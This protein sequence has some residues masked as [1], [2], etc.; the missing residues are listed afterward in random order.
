[1]KKI[2]ELLGTIFYFCISATQGTLLNQ[3]LRNCFSATQVA[4]RNQGLRNN[5]LFLLFCFSAFL[6]FSA[7]AQC[8]PTITVNST[9][10]STC[11]SDGSVTFT[12]GGSGG[13]NASTDVQ[14]QLVRNGNP[15]TPSG[16]WVLV[17]GSGGGLTLTI[18]DLEPGNYDITIRVFCSGDWSVETAATS[19]AITGSYV[20]LTSSIGTITDVSGTCLGEI[21]ISWSGGI[22]PVTISW[23]G[24][25]T[26][27]F[28]V[29]ENSTRMINVPV[30]TFN[31]TVTDGCVSKTYPNVMMNAT[32]PT[33]PTTW[34]YNQLGRGRNCNEVQ[35]YT[36]YSLD[37][38]T[39]K[40]YECGYSTTNNPA[41][42]VTWEPYYNSAGRLPIYT[43]PSTFAN[44]QAFCAAGGAASNPL[45]LHIRAICDHN[46]TASVSMRSTTYLCRS[47][48]SNVIKFPSSSL[49][50]GVEGDCS[51]VTGNIYLDYYYGICYPVKWEIENVA[52]PGVIIAS[53]TTISS[54]GTNANVTLTSTTPFLRGETYKVTC[55]DNNG[56]GVTFTV[57]FTTPAFSPKTYSGI[58]YPAPGLYNKS[59]IGMTYLQIKPTPNYFFPG[60]VIRYDSG[61]QDLAMGGAGSSYTIS[62]SNRSNF[63]ATAY[64]TNGPIYSS[65]LEKGTY[66]FTV[67][68]PAGCGDEETVSITVSGDF[69]RLAD[70]QDF[71]Y[72][73][74]E[75]LDCDGVPVTFTGEI[76]LQSGTPAN[77]Y[78]YVG[79]VS[80]GVGS[81]SGVTH[82]LPSGTTVKLKPSEK[83]YY[84][85][86]YTH[87]PENIGSICWIV[88]KEFYI[89]VPGLSLQPDSA[90][91]YACQGSLTGRIRVQAT[92]GTP[93]YTYRVTNDPD[94]PST[95]P[96]DQ[97]RTDGVF[98]SVGV[99]NGN[100]II[101]VTD[102]CD[103]NFE[104]KVKILDLSNV[105]VIYVPY[106]GNFCEGSQIE[107]NCYSLG[108][109]T[110]TWTK[111]D[112]PDFIKYGQHPRFPCEY[113]GSTGTYQVSVT[114]EGCGEPTISD[115]FVTA[116]PAPA[117][118]SL[119]DANITLC[120]NSGTQDIVALSGATPHPT[121]TLQWYDSG[122]NEIPP[123]TEHPTT[124]LGTTTYYVMPIEIA[125]T[126]EP[127]IQKITVSVNNCS[128]VTPTATPKQI[129]E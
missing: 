116:L 109:T 104:M 49:W 74:G 127:I 82:A 79:Q 44:H 113:P 4:F 98:T 59:N 53:G 92:S 63:Q 24:T 8:I 36:Y 117:L 13:I 17:P 26:G 57:N 43:Y 107:L 106:S 115:A 56:A 123:P 1:M 29:N 47:N 66:N 91:A 112:D 108:R 42:V 23:T 126:C 35:P 75:T 9:T 52:D 6:P 2:Y 3:G 15:V 89:K 48:Y 33:I 100:Y 34:T 41:D 84:I 101:K 69:Y 46:V 45:Y 60:T 12:V 5:F 97:T 88:T 68:P 55:T 14:Y 86:M 114:A 90:S 122:N 118:A 25:T 67:I 125:G 40:L 50:Q 103:Y 102:F 20:G 30:G 93:P 37:N 85:H 58:F 96:E 83:P 54:P 73:I 129:C 111:L 105:N 10:T 70:Q 119:S 65:P 38:S 22:R 94:D 51:F 77:T 87:D 99:P 72:S 76:L 128:C 21:P 18:Q 95:P 124:T 121:H 32:P 16:T 120:Q 81:V 61:P 80:S 19:F 28:N 62:E 7:N 31:I 64:D 71:E 110:Y 78:F 11:L 27:S 39:F